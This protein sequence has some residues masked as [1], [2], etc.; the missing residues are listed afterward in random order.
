MALIKTLAT[1]FCVLALGM[2]GGFAVL[3]IIDVL[4]APPK[5]APESPV[6]PEAPKP[7]VEEAPGG[8]GETGEASEP[9]DGE[10]IFKTF[11]TQFGAKFTSVDCLKNSRLENGTEFGADNIIHYVDGTISRYMVGGYRHISDTAIEFSVD[12]ENSEIYTIDQDTIVMSGLKISN[13]VIQEP[14][15]DPVTKTSRKM[16]A[17][18]A[19]PK[20]PP[21]KLEPSPV[22]TEVEALRMAIQASD[23]DAAI[24]FLSHGASLPARDLE[25]GLAEA[26]LSES[27]KANIRDQ[28]RRNAAVHGA[29]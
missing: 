11:V 17:C 4:R 29:K 6:A 8:H 16:I 28:N 13:I 3:H 1:Y 19:R 12:E 26:S 15:V 9:K 20:G 27:Y 24:G 7:A 21:D 5:P 14:S 23:G 18:P 22:Y 25:Q 2:G 10:G